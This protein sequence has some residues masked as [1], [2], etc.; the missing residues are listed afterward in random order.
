MTKSSGEGCLLFTGT[1]NGRGYGYFWDGKKVTLA[2]RAAWALEKGPI[3]KNRFVLHR[4]D[5]KLCVNVAHLLLGTPQDNVDDMLRKGRGRN[6]L[7]EKNRAKTHCVHGH[8][9]AGK[10]LGLKSNGSRYCLA[11]NRIALRKKAARLG[12]W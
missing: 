11:C 4:C 3:P 2:H 5:V 9:L 6:L 12:H 1:T 8:R 10:D 7:F